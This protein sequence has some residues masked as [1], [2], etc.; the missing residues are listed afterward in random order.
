MLLL[1][2][3]LYKRRSNL[4]FHYILF[5]RGF[6]TH[7]IINITKR[8]MD[9]ESDFSSDNLFSYLTLWKITCHA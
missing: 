7:K 8:F 3:L 1:H 4:H 9:F 5:G 6:V 2:I